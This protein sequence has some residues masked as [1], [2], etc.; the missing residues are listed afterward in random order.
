MDYITKDRTIIFNPYF[1]NEIKTE[2]LLDF[3]KVIF[4]NY[5]LNDNLFEAYELNNFN[6]L[7]IASSSIF[8]LPINLPTNIIHFNFW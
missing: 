1:N 7:N 8:N 3:D 2:L 6:E 4:S 5:E